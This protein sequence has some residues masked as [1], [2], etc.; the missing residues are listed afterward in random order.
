MHVQGE[1]FKWMA[2]EGV[3]CFNTG[4]FEHKGKKYEL[5][6]EIREMKE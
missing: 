1:L 3:K 5:V 4:P 6:A 2:K